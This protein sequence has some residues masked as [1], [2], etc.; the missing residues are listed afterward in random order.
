MQETQTQ[1]TQRKNMYISYVLA[2]AKGIE[3]TEA[4]IKEADMKWE[5]QNNPEIHRELN[6]WKMR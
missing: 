1:R 4:L 3:D 5:Q 2:H 6:H